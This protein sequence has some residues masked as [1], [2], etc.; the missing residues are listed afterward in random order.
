MPLWEI[1]G[2]KAQNFHKCL[3]SRWGGD[4]PSPTY[5][6]PD[7]KKTAFIFDDFPQ[8][9]HTFAALVLILAFVLM[10]DEGVQ[11]DRVGNPN[12][13]RALVTTVLLID[14]R[15]GG[16]DPGGEDDGG[17]GVGEWFNSSQ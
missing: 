2:E 9:S 3:W 13:P 14:C 4:P 6:Q 7:R 16:G 15:G 1:M 12:E 8:G 10:G 5:G 17:G 11:A